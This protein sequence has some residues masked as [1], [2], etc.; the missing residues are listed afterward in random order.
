MRQIFSPGSFILRVTWSH[1]EKPFLF[2]TMNS[3]SLCRS[4]IRSF[5]A[6][7]SAKLGHVAFPIRYKSIVVLG[8][9]IMYRSFSAIMLHVLA[10]LPLRSM[11]AVWDCIIAQEMAHVHR[12]VRLDPPK[13][14]P[15]NIVYIA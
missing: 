5:R 8:R 10:I 4:M 14:S 11:D 6:R 3:T 2:A 1:A 15:V 13:A 7:F 9:S 12:A